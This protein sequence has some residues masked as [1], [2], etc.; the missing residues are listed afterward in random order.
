MGKRTYRVLWVPGATQDLVDIGSYIALDSPANAM[1]VIKRI[2]QRASTLTTMP[3]RGRILAEGKFLGETRWRE[4]IVRPYRIIYA[5]DDDSVKVL[6]IID[7]R[8]EFEDVL[9][10]IVSRSP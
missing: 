9:F 10:E 6:A 5:I 7:S 3:A 1:N 8:R 2:Q 4:L